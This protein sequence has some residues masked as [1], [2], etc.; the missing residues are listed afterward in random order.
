MRAHDCPPSTGNLIYQRRWKAASRIRCAIKGHKLFT[1][2][3][4]SFTN[5]SVSAVEGF[6]RS[7]CRPWHCCFLTIII[8]PGSAVCNVFIFL[9]KVL[10]RPLQD[11]SL[12]LLPLHRWEGP[13]F[14]TLVTSWVTCVGTMLNEFWTLGAGYKQFRLSFKIFLKTAKRPAFEFW[15]RQKRY[16]LVLKANQPTSHPT[17]PNQIIPRLCLYIRDTKGYKNENKVFLIAKRKKKH[18]KWEIK[19]KETLLRP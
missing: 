3:R 11:P 19:E 7:F 10:I 13:D 6:W 1:C 17:K 15:D 9:M 12:S 18:K 5:M 4:K 8:W 2:H 16:Q 14:C